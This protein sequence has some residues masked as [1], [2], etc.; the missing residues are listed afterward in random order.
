VSFANPE[1]EPAIGGNAQIAHSTP[2]DTGSLSLDQA[3]LDHAIRDLRSAG[4]PEQRAA[5]AC[6]LGIIGGQLATAHLIAAL[7]DRVPEVRRAGAEALR[8]AADPAVASAPLN[9]L[10]E[11]DGEQQAPERL[12]E[13]A[14]P[15]AATP[16]P[17][18]AAATWP[19]LAN[20]IVA[21][22]SEVPD[23][24]RLLKEET[25]AREA[26]EDLERRLIEVESLRA[27]A[28]R[29][30]RLQAER[31]VGFRSN[32][33]GRRREEEQLRVRVQELAYERLEQERGLSAA[34]EARA[35]AEAEVWRLS[36]DEESLRLDAL[37]PRQ[38]AAELAQKRMA[39][40][41]AL[42]SAAHASRRAEAERVLQET[43]ARHEAELELLRVAEDELRQVVAEA[44]LARTQVEDLR[45]EAKQQVEHFYEEQSRLA[46]LE[47]GRLAE[48]EQLREEAEA[49]AGEE[50]ERWSREADA[51]RRT[52]DQ[53]ALRRAEMEAA[54]LRAEEETQLL[55][56]AQARIQHDEEAR[57]QTQEEYLRLEAEAWQ[58]ATETQHLLEELRQRTGDEQQSL[59][60]EARLRGEQEERRL[61]E[62]EE[63]RQRMKVASRQRAEKEEQLR[64]EIEELWLAEAA[65]RQRIQDTEARLRVAAEAHRCA[66]EEARFKVEEEVGARRRVA[67]ERQKNP[68][69]GARRPE[70][71]LVEVEAPNTEIGELP[72]QR[73]KSLSLIDGAASDLPPAIFA[74]L[75]SV[76]PQTRA[77]TLTELAQSGAKPAFSLISRFFDDS[78]AAVRNAAARAL[79][80]LQ[81]YQT[82]ELLNRALEG[83]SPERCQRIV[84]ALIASGLA[85]EAVDDLSGESRERTYN[86]LCL[87]FVI[88]KNGRL[89]PLVEA[90][91]SNQNLEV[92]QAAVKLLTLC[93]QPDIAAAAVKRRLNI[94]PKT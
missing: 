61:A 66:E 49:R 83:A 52:N 90:I 14:S 9:A 80:E 87:L 12:P 23:L 50:R 46:A 85:A 28:E 13:N 3:D 34:M 94:F 11:A 65:Q 31:E 43:T 74:G 20:T 59:D 71:T 62:L 89:E 64:N 38:L 25:A 53:V 1:L 67:E 45:L 27:R 36:R 81:P 47:A 86:A 18:E 41:A 16:A 68:M 17:S 8:R 30:V 35:Q 15:T 24:A 55:A 77:A 76:D 5:A 54:R 21:G 22:V 60:E 51:L 93:G 63:L 37:R 57:R 7:F 6:T 72:L 39:G 58:R 48:L 91:E 33:A 29:A 32:L 78:S 56:E 19:I 10:L 84:A 42:I 79:R 69:A 40:A 73:E 26:V 75:H 92:R 44:A 2:S 4:S 82:A 70:Q 88:A